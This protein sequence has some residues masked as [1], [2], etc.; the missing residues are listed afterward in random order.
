M[1]QIPRLMPTYVAQATLILGPFYGIAAR[2]MTIVKAIGVRDMLYLIVVEF[3]APECGRTAVMI[4][5]T[6]VAG[7]RE[8][9]LYD[10]TSTPPENLANQNNCNI[11]S[12]LSK[13]KNK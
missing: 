11:A 2:K 8:L 5:A 12:I 10:R 3:V 7:G 4:V 9:K 6:V 1:G 13:V